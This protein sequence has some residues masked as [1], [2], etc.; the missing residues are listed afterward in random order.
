MLQT[1]RDKL[2]GWV[3]IVIFIFIGLAFALWGIDLGGANV[4]YAAKVNGE[5]ISLN[6]FRLQQQNQMA[7]YA[8]FYPDGIPAEVE[9]RLR[10]NLLDSLIRE[11]LLSQQAQALNYRVGDLAIAEAIQGT[12][13]F[14]VDGEFSM[15][16]Y[17]ARLV[18]NGLNPAGYEASMRKS[19]RN[20]QL[21]SGIAGSTFVTPDELQR[22]VA[23]QD[24]Q[25]EAA[26]AIIPAQAFV[27]QVQVSEEAIVAEYEANPQDYQSPETVSVQYLLLPRDVGESS[28]QISDEELSDYYD[29]ERAIGRF[30]GVEERRARH[31]LV[32]V[33]GDTDD[34]SAR[35][36]AE[37]ALARINEGEDFATLAGELS[38]DPGSRSQGGD[39]G[40]AD[41]DIYV[42]PF[43]EALLNLEP[44]Q[45]AGPI[46]TQ[47]GYHIIRLEEV[48]DASDKSLADVR[49]EL[50]AE[51]RASKEEEI[52]FRRADELRDFAFEAFN[53]LDSVAQ[54]MGLEAMSLAG[55]TRTGGPG[56]AA[57]R[58]FRDEAFSDPVLLD[59]EN[60]GPILLDEGVVVLRVTDHQVSDLL[61][62][63]DVRARIRG[64]LARVEAESLAAEQGRAAVEQGRARGQ[65]ASEDLP[66]VAVFSEARLI[67]RNEVGISP[68]LLAAVFSA[69]AKSGDEAYVNG[70]SL[71]NGDYAAYAVLSVQPGDVNSLTAEERDQR[72]RQLAS[73]IGGLE[74]AAY[75]D[76]LRSEASVIVNEE[77]LE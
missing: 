46:R 34:A 8:Q 10:Q 2:T 13:S 39:L 44:G 37:A 38:D 59:S 9:D 31:I 42:P 24:Q 69:P 18:A 55:I 73:R 23:L 70:L 35:E 62:L 36:L 29:Q 3:A 7:R 5:D 16:L 75:V 77:Q 41:P 21:Q 67:G 57:T 14:Q 15:D 50:M 17:R 63:D 12:P 47:F 22:Y 66:E 25:R 40:F 56:I 74:L 32:A 45:V 52:F 4:N 76:R 68:D 53:E 72:R 26:W 43:K 58:E 27:E 6:D 49:D 48:S 19:L 30:G 28:V 20:A 64:D 33:D 11:E 65:L 1:I 60:S 51:L 71:T 54:R 61:P